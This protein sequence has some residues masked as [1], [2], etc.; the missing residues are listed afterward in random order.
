MNQSTPSK[1]THQQELLVTCKQ[2]DITLDTEC[3]L[4]IHT[5][6]KHESAEPY[7]CPKCPYTTIDS[8]NL[9]EHEGN[10][11]HG[12]QKGEDFLSIIKDEITLFKCAEC[13]I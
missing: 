1:M 4:A 11:H 12:Y 8:K 7:K 3:N 5:K 2:C 9:H 13:E 6:E 10:T